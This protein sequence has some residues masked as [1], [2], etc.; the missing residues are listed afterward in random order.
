MAAIAFSVAVTASATAQSVQ[1]FIPDPVA[2]Y[3]GVAVTSDNIVWYT[4]SSAGLVGG[5][6]DGETIPFLVVPTPDS[7]PS[8]MTVGPDGN[9]WFLEGKAQK[10]ARINHDRSILE[11]PLPCAVSDSGL[12]GGSDALWLAERCPTYEALL[13]VAS[14]GAMTTYI[15]A[16]SLA[17]V[18]SITETPDGNIWYTAAQR[19]SIGKLDLSGPFISE[20]AIPTASSSPM[21][22]LVG[23][24]GAIWFEEYSARQIARIDISSGAT[25]ISEY[26][27][28]DT[29]MPIG[30]ASS[31]GKLWA[32]DSM[33]RVWNFSLSDGAINRQPI[34]SKESN[35]TA[36]ALSKAANGNLWFTENGTRGASALG[37]IRMDGVFAD[38]LEA[39]L[40]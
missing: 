3:G 29:L 21:F 5:Y 9:P 38:N 39:A 32:I 2:A 19:N 15:I 36:V 37:L 16:P 27:W 30:L 6:H 22:I 25:A 33:K 24:D 1:E 8:S 26:A 10:L 4:E 34:A 17:R 18:T 20:I 11:I 14:D 28:P 12:Y 35:L 23:P 13:R 40:P 7:T 31:S